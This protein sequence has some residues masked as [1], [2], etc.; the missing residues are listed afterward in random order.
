MADPYDEPKSMIFMHA[1]DI[2]PELTGK[3]S[4]PDYLR[5]TVGGLTEK[6]LGR[7]QD[8]GALRKTTR[9]RVVLRVEELPED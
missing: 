8:K 3:A 6:I 7:M 4:T 1:A 5:T 9:Y 2:A